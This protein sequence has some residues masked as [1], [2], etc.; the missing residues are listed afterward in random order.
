MPP[1]E[2]VSAGTQMTPVDGAADAAAS[3]SDPLAAARDWSVGADDDDD[4]RRG[5]RLR[6]AGRLLGRLRRRPADRAARRAVRADAAAAAAA[7]LDLTGRRRPRVARAG[8]GR[9]RRPRKNSMEKLGPQPPPMRPG[10][11]PAPDDADQLA[12]RSAE[13]TYHVSKRGPASSSTT[14]G[15]GRGHRAPEAPRVDRFFHRRQ[16]LVAPRRAT[17]VTGGAECVGV[18]L[19]EC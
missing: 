2:R 4:G 19:G 15:G 5:A 1:K 13:G 17:V 14:L 10:A 7:R 9:L 8:P 6:L 12:R 18:H 16:R 3:T 11:G